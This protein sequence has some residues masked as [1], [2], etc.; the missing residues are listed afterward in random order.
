MH[1]RD[2]ILGEV[3][4]LSWATLRPTEV[5]IFLDVAMSALFMGVS[6]RSSESS[7]SSS[8]CPVRPNE[9]SRPSYRN[10]GRGRHNQKQSI[11]LLQ[12]DH[13][14]GSAPRATACT[15]GLEHPEPPNLSG[16]WYARRG[17]CT[18]LV[19]SNDLPQGVESGVE[20]LRSSRQD[21]MCDDGPPP[22]VLGGH[23]LLHLG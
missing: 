7:I 21:S 18:N 3:I 14:D 19:V 4:T 5:S 8:T 23:V 6:F 15:T 13:V 17:L 1:P 20:D 10:E 11:G 12:W 9:Q 22:R 16:I 2:K